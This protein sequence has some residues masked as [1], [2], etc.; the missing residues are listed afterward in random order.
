MLTGTIMEKLFMWVINHSPDWKGLNFKFAYGREFILVL[1]AY[2]QP[3][4][5]EA[6]GPRGKSTDIV[7]LNYHAVKPP[8]KSLYFY[9][10]YFC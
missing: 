10:H 8:S 9:L 3:M 7:L 4:A 1:K 5:W 6:I 2:S